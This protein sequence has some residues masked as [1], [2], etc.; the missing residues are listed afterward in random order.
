MAELLKGK[1]VADA[2][3]EKCR[4][5]A[6]ELK[7]KGIIPTLAIIRCGEDPSD[8]S[9]ERGAMKRCE[10]VGVEVRNVVMPRDVEPEEFYKTVKQISDDPEIH[11]IL[12]F[13]PLPKQLDA[14]TARELMNP[15]KDVDGCTQGS[16]TG[17][18]TNTKQG[19]AP[20]TAQA[21]I[22]IFDYYGIELSGKNAVLIGR[23]LVVGKPLA[24]L[25]LNRNATVTI[26]HT[27]TK[28]LPEI[29]KKAEIVVTAIGVPEKFGAEYFSEGQIAA[30]V[31][32]SW[33]E[34]KQKL[35]GDIFFEE[36][37]PVV[38][39]ITPV[40]GGVGSVTTAVLVS[41]V[42]EAAQRLNGF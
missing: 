21:V 6:A 27:R 31:G 34:T 2:L 5:K 41:H 25:M 35:T 10:S 32:I 30:D 8:L 33:N 14:I 15:A 39:K 36:A 20:C 42:I 9:Y 12:M 40:P 26:C 4:E 11:G 29:T 28:D 38:S 18:Y 22:E 7:E 3:T 17:V 19:F 1:P 23:S 24:M 13:R 16:M 37:E